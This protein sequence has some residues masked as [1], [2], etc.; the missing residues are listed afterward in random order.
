[1][2][3]NPLDDA[4]LVHFAIPDSGWTADR[5]RLSE[6]DIQALRSLIRHPLLDDVEGVF[7]A[8]LQQIFAAAVES[9]MFWRRLRKEGG[10]STLCASHR[11][12]LRLDRHPKLGTI[13]QEELRVLTDCHALANADPSKGSRTV[14]TRSLREANEVTR[15]IIEILMLERCGYEP[16][17]GSGKYAVTPNEFEELG[18]VIEDAKAIVSTNLKPGAAEPAMEQMARGLAGLYL[19]AT[20]ELPK[21]SFRGEPPKHDETLRGNCGDFIDLCRHMAV[22]VIEALPEN[23]RR[24]NPVDMAKPAM[25]MMTELKL[26]SLPN[27]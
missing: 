21:R 7:D 16:S 22:L 5:V 19:R 17:L 14:F 23:L 4:R 13:V 3:G 25:R 20:G 24:S 1:M 18:R 6:N 15:R 12:S 8:L 11:S 2:T 27:G 10:Q 9:E 26:E